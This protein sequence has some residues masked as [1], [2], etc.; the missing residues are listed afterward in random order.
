MA[1]GK[2][3]TQKKKLKVPAQDTPKLNADQ[4]RAQH[5]L[6]HVL[7]LV[8]GE[9]ALSLPAQAKFKAYLQSLPAMIQINGLGQAIAF[10]RSRFSSPIDLKDDS[11]KAYHKLY[12][13][14]SDWLIGGE[15]GVYKAAP[16]TDLLQQLTSQDMHQYQRAQV[17]L[18]QYL[19]WLKKFT[20]AYVET[21][22][23]KEEGHGETS[24]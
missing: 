8:D 21:E 4:V 16:N 11:Q 10:Y 13:L 3:N 14:I 15:L 12:E 17:E 20:L 22:A 2:K 1:K 9:H 23:K 24:L 5:A 6:R 19:G 18:L 7:T